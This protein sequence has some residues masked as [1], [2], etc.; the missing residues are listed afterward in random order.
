MMQ[1]Y[2]QVPSFEKIQSEL[3]KLEN[4]KNA[5]LKKD[6]PVLYIAMQKKLSVLQ[7]Q[8]RELA[9]KMKI[10]LA[11]FDPGYYGKAQCLKCRG[12]GQ[13]LN[14]ALKCDCWKRGR[15]PE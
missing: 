11:R 8:R 2:E 4:P 3:E 7:A 12:T 1:V 5:T 10:D 15:R 6:N 9:L 14:G 13:A